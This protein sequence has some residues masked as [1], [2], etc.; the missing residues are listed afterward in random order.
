M[1]TGLGCTFPG[2]TGSFMKFTEIKQPP[3]SGL[4]VLIDENEDAIWDETFGY[5]SPNGY[6]S[7]YW[8]DLPADRHSQ[9]ANLSFADGHVEHWKWKAPKIY[10]D[11]AEPAYNA[12]DLADL[13]RLQQCENPGG[14]S[15]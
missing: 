2:I 6:Y 15:D 10:Y 13:Q 7:D 4:F 14:G 3:P 11:N 1:E 9:G 5:W 12:G 8:I